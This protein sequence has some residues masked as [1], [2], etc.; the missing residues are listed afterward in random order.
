L[1]GLEMRGRRVFVTGAYGLLGSW[2]VK[3]LLKRGDEVVALR[4][5]STHRSALV[6]DGIERHIDIVDGDVTDALLMHRTFAEYEVELVFHLAAQTL[7][8]AASRSPV[9]TFESNIRGTWTV[10]EAA[11]VVGVSGLVVAASDKVYGDHERQPYREHFALLP[12]YP[13]D[14]SKAACDMLA[15]SYWHTYG[16][17]VA[18]TRMA[19][20]YG[21]GDLN[22]SRLIPELVMS[23]LTGERPIIRSDGT[24]ERDYLYVED[25]VSA[26][27]MITEA[28]LDGELAGEAFNAGWG[29]PRSVREVVVLALAAAGSQ[30]EPDFQGSGKPRGEIDRQFLDSSKLRQATG[31]EPHVPLEDGLQRTVSW[32]A[33]HLADLAPG[34]PESATAARP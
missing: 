19:N 30:I 14:V 5:D 17:P 34:L 27:L 20:L 25:A 11:R 6:L 1:E 26:Y 24:P 31:W 28:L 8:G 4:R 23:A 3:A 16:V 32:Y 10:L 21:G 18:V 13:Y 2:L 15:R 29:E 33:N 9:A 22:R 12:R 7:V